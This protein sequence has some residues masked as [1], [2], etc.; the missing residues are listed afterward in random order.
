MKVSLG[1]LSMSASAGINPAEMEISEN[2]VKDLIA[3][4]KLSS[5]RMSLASSPRRISRLRCC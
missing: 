4:H 2:G 1:I 5:E 3:S